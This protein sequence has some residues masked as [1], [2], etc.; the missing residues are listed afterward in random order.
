M[1][2]ITKEGD[3]QISSK[4]VDSLVSNSN[5]DK[6]KK[7]FFF[8][9]IGSFDSK[10]DNFIQNIIQ[11]SSYS[12]FSNQLKA[13]YD[14]SDCERVHLSFWYEGLSIE[15]LHIMKFMF[16]LSSCFLIHLNISNDNIFDDI[17]VF[18][19]QSLFFYAIS[20][21]KNNKMKKAIIVLL[22]NN[23]SSILNSPDKYLKEL[24]Q[25]WKN[26]LNV[27]NINDPISLND[28]F[29]FDFFNNN[30]L[31]VENIQN[32]IINSSKFEKTW[33]N[34]VYNP[35]SLQDMINKRWIWS[36][37]L[38]KELL[39]SAEDK[40]LKEIML[41]Y[42]ADSAFHEV[43]QYS[44]QIL[45]KWG[46]IVYKGKTINNYGKIVSNFL[47]NVNQKFD[48]LIPKDFDKDQVSIK[49][50]LKINNIVQQRILFLFTKQLLNLQ[51]Q[52]L[53]KFKDTLL[54]IASDSKKNFDSEKKL[55]IDSVNQW[56]ISHA[57]A[58]VS[59]NI[60]LSYIAAQKELDNVLIEF[61][62]KFKESPIVKLQSLQRL[63]KQTSTS[64]LKQSGIVIGFGLTAALRPHGFGNFQLITSYTQGPHVFNFSLVNDRD[65]AEQEGQ[66]KIKPFRIQPSLNF[67]I[68]L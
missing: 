20:E 26:C 68:E 38:P 50:K 49:K 52:A 37:A 6:K 62:E 60:R 7:L 4:W 5:K 31:D 25:L 24:E 30:T 44:Q 34:V 32:S 43:L 61:S 18:I 12:K 42:F 65:I 28:Y 66:G 19:I 2:T 11:D 56:F 59:N 21:I 47:E 8:S 45:K 23:D 35:A 1:L 55:A 9:H 41:F 48:S 39:I 17:N 67:D 64:G 29:E 27:N 46:K 15:L 33:D 57:E 40:T 14:S 54:K 16:L 51:S 36:S 53:E 22:I 63:E 10:A 13:S 58:L 3:L